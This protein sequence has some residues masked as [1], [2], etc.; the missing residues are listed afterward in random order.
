[1]SIKSSQKNIFFH[2]IGHGH[3]FGLVL[4]KARQDCFLD[5]QDTWRLPTYNMKPVNDLRSKALPPQSASTYPFIE[6]PSVLNEFFLTQN[7]FSRLHMF[8]MRFWIPLQQ[9]RYGMTH[10]WSRCNY[11][12]HKRPNNQLIVML[13]Y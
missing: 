7:S 11:Q 5:S 13:V 10:V 3:I 8:S 2:S 12:I 9:F 6:F 4:L 1:M